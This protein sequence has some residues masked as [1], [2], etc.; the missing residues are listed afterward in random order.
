M[1]GRAKTIRAYAYILKKHGDD[2]TYVNFQYKEMAAKNHTR[3]HSC[4]MRVLRPVGV[5]GNVLV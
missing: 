1:P 5:T 3:T 2:A 4:L